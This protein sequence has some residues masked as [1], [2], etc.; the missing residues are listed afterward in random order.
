[1]QNVEIVNLMGCL[2]IP[3]D[4]EL[5]IRDHC[6]DEE[7][8]RHECLYYYLNF[9]PYSLCSWS[10]LRG[11]LQFCEEEAALTL[12]KEYL[13]RAPGICGC[14][15]CTY[16]DEED[17]YDHVYMTQQIHACSDVHC[18][19][20]SAFVD[21]TDAHTNHI[22]AHVHLTTQNQHWCWIT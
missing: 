18:V 15:M 17:A 7:Q 12:S 13:Q 8:Q 4:V 3:V 9:S 10:F 16:W 19:C 5:M 6:T 1:M 21:Y 20:S 14:G 2:N 11:E 22:C